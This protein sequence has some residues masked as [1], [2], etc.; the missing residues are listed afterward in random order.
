MSKKYTVQI[1]RISYAFSSIEIE[2]ESALEAEVTAYDLSGDLCYSEK[3][4]EYT[5][6]SVI[7]G[8]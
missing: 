5:I 7:E 3:E 1:C 4:A 8:K 6:E 2:A